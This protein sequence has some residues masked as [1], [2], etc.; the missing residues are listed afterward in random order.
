MVAGQKGNHKKKQV[1]MSLKIISRRKHQTRAIYING[2]NSVRKLRKQGVTQH[3]ARKKDKSLISIL[4]S[5]FY[6]ISENLLLSKM[7]RS[8]HFEI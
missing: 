8:F 7:W 6:V 4:V 5:S 2:V 1:K 3:I